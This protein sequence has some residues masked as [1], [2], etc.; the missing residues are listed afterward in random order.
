MRGLKAI[1]G[2]L[3]AAA[4]LA[5]PA[6]AAPWTVKREQA[7]AE[8]RFLASDALQG[9]GSA[10]RDEAIAAA[11]VAAQFEGF[12]LTPAPGQAG[13]FQ[14][15]KVIKPRLQGEAKVRIDG[16]DVAGAQ[17][18]IGPMGD[19]GGKAVVFAADDVMTMPAAEVVI[20]TSK[21][22][23]LTVGQTAMSKQVKLLILKES[24]LTKGLYAAQGGTDMASYLEGTPQGVRTAVATLP[25]EAFERLAAHPGASVDL[26]LPPMTR[27]TAITTNAIGY[28]KG[29][30]PKA[31][32]LVVSAHLDHLGVRPNG[33]IMHGANDDASG[34][35]AVIELARAFTAG[36]PPKRSILFIGYGSEEI[37]K[38]GSTWFAAH[39]SVPLAEI[40]AAIEFEMVGQQDPKLPK[41]ALFVTGSERSTLMGALKAHGAPVA[42]DS[43]PAQHYFERSDNWPLAQ[44]G[45]VAHTLAG[46]TTTPTY[47]QA[48]DTFES[49]DLTFLTGAIQSMVSPL[50]WLADSDFRPAWIAGGRPPP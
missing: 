28:L 19:V 29:R 31:G 27:E 2:L 23:P 43:D 4:A 46:W 25:A 20:S 32:T 15:A 48:S 26:K 17:L 3:A 13:F 24:F 42:P 36:K 9:R 41:G 30:D 6:Q 49:L 10:T 50:R 16:V 37:G 14:T 8:A 7:A 45:V 5:G 38:Y 22:S 40:V 18:L 1:F 33:T 47:H 44:A 21:A 39:P 12:G 11:Y 35:V 34:M